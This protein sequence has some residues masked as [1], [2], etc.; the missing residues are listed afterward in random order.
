MTSLIHWG[1]PSKD[2]FDI[3]EKVRKGK[4]LSPEQ[5]D[6]M[7]KNQVPEWYIESCKKIKYMF[8]KAHAAAYSI[9]SLRIAWFKVY[10]PEAFYAAYFTVRSAGSFDCTIMCG[11][12][13]EIGLQIKRLNEIL[14]GFE[15]TEKDKKT[16]EL[17]ELVEEMLARNISFLPL[18]INQSDGSRFGVEGTGLIRPS[19]DSIPGISPAMGDKIVAE[20][21]CNGLFKNQEEAAARCGLGPSAVAALRACGAFG[22]LPESAQL[23]LF[24]LL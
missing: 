4:K 15:A 10:R 7:R 19:L 9:S 5:L 23:D 2:S 18:D 1:L 6:L 14:K 17:L 24:S 22:D 3:M 21:A 13:R 20:R 12:A 11:N 16:L 8:P